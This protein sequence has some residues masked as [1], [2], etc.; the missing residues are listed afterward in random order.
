MGESPKN[1]RSKNREKPGIVGNS[2]IIY[3][4]V[5]G[6]ERGQKMSSENGIFRSPTLTLCVPREALTS[7]ICGHCHDKRAFCLS[8][9]CPHML[10]LE[11][12]E[13]PPPAYGNC[14]RNP[15]VR[16]VSVPTHPAL[17]EAM[18]S[19][20][21]IQLTYHDGRNTLTSAMRQTADRPR[22]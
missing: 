11:K 16:I 18:V 13:R 5:T 4:G 15:L 22:R 10:L 1:W 21:I 3:S 20:R 14:F 8:W 6:P 7:S 19:R 9:Q 17:I 12:R 2:V